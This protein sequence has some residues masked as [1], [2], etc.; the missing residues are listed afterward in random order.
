MFT[1]P[2]GDLGAVQNMSRDW[3]IEKFMIAVTYDTN[4][5]KARK[6]I[7][8]IGQDLAADPELGKQ[9]IE[10]LKMQGVEQF[11]DYGIQIRMKMTTKPGEQFV[12]RRRRSLASSRLLTRTASASLCP[13]C[14]LAGA[15]KALRWP[16]R[17]RSSSGFDLS[18]RP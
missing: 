10:P 12:I 5:E 17:S 7:K 8:N 14:K 11:G 15:R 18:H 9:V 2:F 3:V 4:L 13:P 6:L 1:V 16:P